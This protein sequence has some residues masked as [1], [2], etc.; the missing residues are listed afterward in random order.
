MVLD[1]RAHLAAIS[2][3]D[4][5]IEAARIEAVYGAA[6]GRE[7]PLVV[8]QPRCDTRRIDLHDE[9][10]ATLAGQI[11]VDEVIEAAERLADP[12]HRLL[13]AR[14][15]NRFRRPFVFQGDEER[16]RGA[17]RRRDAVAQHVTQLR[18]IAGVRIQRAVRFEEGLFVVDAP[19][20]PRDGVPWDLL[21]LRRERIHE[22]LAGLEVVGSHDHGE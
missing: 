11:P 12:V 17:L 2:H 22:S 21:Q 7:D 4:A 6:H 8:L 16:I 18:E 15:A 1:Q 19:E 10:L 3:P 9:R 14:L 5:R 20:D 13:D